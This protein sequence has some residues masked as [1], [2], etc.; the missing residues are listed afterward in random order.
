M[1]RLHIIQDLRFQSKIEPV[2]DATEC[3]PEQTFLL[4]AYD[5]KKHTHSIGWADLM[6]KAS[7]GPEFVW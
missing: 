1:L 7:P 2:R 6:K 3:M 5:K 4:P